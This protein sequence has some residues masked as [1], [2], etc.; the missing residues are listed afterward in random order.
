MASSRGTWAC[1]P[2][3]G[4]CARRA[5]ARI[6]SWAIS[7]TPPCI[8]TSSTGFGPPR[9]IPRFATKSM[10]CTAGPRWAW[11][12]ASFH[13][14]PTLKALGCT[15]EQVDQLLLTKVMEQQVDE[16]EVEKGFRWFERL[17]GDRIRYDGKML[18]PE[19]LKTQLRLYLAM[20]LVNKEHGFDF[21]GLKGQRELTE[22]VCLG[23]VPEMLLNDPVRLVRPKRADGL[24][25][26]GGLLRRH[27]YATAQVHLRRAALAVHG[28]R[29]YRP[30]LDLWD[31]CNSGNHASWYA[32]QSMDPAVNFQRITLHPALEF[33]FKAGGASVEFN[34]KAGPMTYARMGLW[35]DKPFM[36]ILKGE[37][38]ELDAEQATGDQRPDGPDLAARARPRARVLCAV[39]VA[40]SCEPRAR[41]RGRQGPR[42]HLSVRDERHHARG[43][44]PRGEREA[45]ADLGTGAL[46]PRTQK[47]PLPDRERLSFSWHA[48]ASRLSWLVLRC[49]LVR[50]TLLRVLIARPH[51][52]R[53]SQAPPPLGAGRIVQEHHRC[54]TPAPPP[55]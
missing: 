21:C 40:L 47:E 28:C 36:A 29:L 38:L 20:N 45:H 51:R 53:R 49:L 33:Y 48:E 17:L 54:R 35:D 3:T 5:F 34:A 50:Q 27:H 8:R 55:C 31:W 13:L 10:D 52:S 11:T 43:S 12:R 7:M 6:A 46:T 4:R 26:R 1:W 37:S 2:L 22:Y 18:T 19:T 9:P 42:A 24:C 23:D 32:E 41:H 39:P 14:V 16:A 44:G 30:E 15:T 25:H